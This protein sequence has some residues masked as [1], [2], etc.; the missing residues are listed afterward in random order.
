MEELEKLERFSGGS[1][2][3][4]ER[5][6]AIYDR[7][8]AGAGSRHGGYGRGYNRKVADSFH[9]PNSRNLA[10]ELE[11]STK[12]I[13]RDIQFMIDRLGVPL[14]YDAQRHGYTLAEGS[15]EWKGLKEFELGVEDLAALFLAKSA[16]RP[17]KGTKLAE[18]LRPAFEKLSELLDGKVS[19]NWND[20]DTVFSMKEMG[21]VDVDLG[22]FGKLAEAALKR[23]EVSFD[24]RKLSGGIGDGRKRPGAVS[25]GEVVER[26]H[27][28]P[29]HVGEISGGWYMIGYDVA[30]SE[31]R[32][33][34]LQRMKRLRVLKATFQM[35]ESFNLTDYLGGSLGAWGDNRSEG[36][37]YKVEIEVSG[38]V[39]RFVQERT[40]HESQQVKRLRDDTSQPGN[41]VAVV[42]YRLARFEELV[43]L[44]LGW[45][46]NAVVLKPEKLRKMVREEL[47]Q[48][49]KRY[50]C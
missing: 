27:V 14:V 45:G 18:S 44:I 33:F 25:T 38:W 17:I 47:K 3:Q 49:M 41:Q 1:K 9:L 39:A 32:T 15:E 2:V 7:V 10:E 24:Y 28:Q 12:T 48:M 8:K 50:E 34:A 37:V 29:Y 31:M 4:M 30:R 43:Q 40:W 5:L 42:E 11:V 22:S 26:R 6:Y 20:L 13:S 46:S 23:K 19:L 36:R 16:L 21:V 35:E